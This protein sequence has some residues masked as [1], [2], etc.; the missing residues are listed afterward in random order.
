MTADELARYDAVGQ[1]ELVQRKELAAVDLAEA[2]IARI[3]RDPALN[4]VIHLLEEP[5]R[6]DARQCPTS[7]PLSG[8]PVGL[9][10]LATEMAGTPLSNGS[11]FL[12][13]YRCERDSTFVR[14]LRSAG[15]VVVG[16]TNASE[17]GVLPTT[18]PAAFGPTLNP[19]DRR[20]SPGGSSGGAAAAVAAGLV[21]AAHGNDGGGSLRI[22]ASCCGVFALNPTRGR[23]P[24][25]P[26]YGDFASGLAREGM[27][28]RSVRDAAAFL[29]ATAGPDV[30]DP[31]CAPAI[32][33]PYAKEVKTPPGRLRIAFGDHGWRLGAEAAQALEQTVSLCLDL[34]HEMVEAPPPPKGEGLS[35]VIL[36]IRAAEC[37]W[38]IDSWTRRLG[39]APEPSELEPLTWDL[40]ERGRRV[41]AAEYLRA[42][43]DVQGLAR[44]IAGHFESID[45]YLTPTTATV[46]PRLGA[47]ASQTV[48]EALLEAA[49]A[50][51]PY[52]MVSSLTGQPAM[53][54]PLY[55]SAEGLPLGSHFTG[56]F[57]GEATLLRLAAQLEQ[58]RPWA[59][60]WPDPALGREEI[61]PER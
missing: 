58:A 50:F 57:G 5:A 59:Q 18:E 3:A 21:P 54:V 32:Q 43:Q 27:I 33:R 30:G 9:K 55:W 10:D 49:R 17:F 6:Q 4:A 26:H 7:A 31:Y 22:P 16:K 8:V 25:G 38:Q 53:S 60:R 24:W 39:R 51:A 15:V 61:A 11:R 48:D 20:R 34:G 29:D 42:W 35:E 46:A 1:A 44:R 19:W 47:F 13:K 28:T 14:R 37:A 45:A 56:R 41:T 52:T 40:Y 36:K 12:R 23:T 2:A